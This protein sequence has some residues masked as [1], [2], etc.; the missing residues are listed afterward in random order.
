MSNHWQADVLRFLDENR[1]SLYDL[2][3]FVF[4]TRLPIHE[5]HRNLLHTRSADFLD[6]WLEQEE[7]NSQDWASH[8]VRETCRNEILKLTEPHTGFRIQA[9]KTSLEQIEEFSMIQLGKDI[10]NKA[11]YLWEIIGVLLDTNLNRRR[12]AP[13]LGRPEGEDVSMENLNDGDGEGKKGVIAGWEDLVDGN[14]TSDSEQSEEQLPIIFES[15]LLHSDLESSSGEDAEDGEP[16][17]KAHRGK[18]NP[19]KRHA[20]LIAIVSDHFLLSIFS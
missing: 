3:I 12:V 16:T 2:L 7:T 14:E 17:K 9:T 4:H 5:H 1:A 8:V 20:I 11:P 18:K 13:Y 6:L 19:G 10:K 15:S